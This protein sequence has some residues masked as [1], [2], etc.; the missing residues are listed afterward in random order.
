M[1]T[2]LRDLLRY[3]DSDTVD[4]MVGVMGQTVLRVPEL[5]E[6]I[7]RRKIRPEERDEVIQEIIDRDENRR[8]RKTTR[9]KRVSE[10]CLSLFGPDD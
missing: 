1:N 6:Y 2:V 9:T 4:K 8:A 10:T 3:F 5:S 7:R